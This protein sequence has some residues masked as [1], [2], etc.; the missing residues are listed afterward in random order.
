MSAEEFFNKAYLIVDFFFG[1]LID[2]WNL[3]RSNWIY[4]V[5]LALFILGFIVSILL[6]IKH[7]K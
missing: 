5:I 6:A 3:M 1:G 4:C 7:I 2:V